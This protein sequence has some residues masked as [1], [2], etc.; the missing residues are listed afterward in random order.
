M[1]HFCV[2][3]ENEACYILS[4]KFS[5]ASVCYIEYLIYGCKK[6]APSTYISTNTAH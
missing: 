5:V 2:M 3:K 6:P 1:K 4:L